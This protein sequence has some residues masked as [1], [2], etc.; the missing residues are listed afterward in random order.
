MD[1]KTMNR[2]IRSIANRGSLLLVLYLAM[3]LPCRFL[4]RFISNAGDC[5]SLWQEPRFMILLME[6]IQY[7]V[8]YP[9]LYIV[10]YT[11]LNRRNGLRLRGVFRKPE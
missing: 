1:N 2:Q 3:I 8:I 5:G 6:I 11:C 10:Y 7:A 4:L 9:V